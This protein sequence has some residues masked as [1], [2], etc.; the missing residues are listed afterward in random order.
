MF[1]TDRAPGGCRYRDLPCIVCGMGA[2]MTDQAVVSA[3]RNV[4]KRYPGVLAVSDVSLDLC[5]GK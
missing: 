1:K 3:L 2:A 4:S 5:A